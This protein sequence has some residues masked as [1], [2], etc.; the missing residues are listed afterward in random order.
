M[1][2][3]E[4]RI[5][6]TEIHELRGDASTHSLIVISNEH[7]EVHE[8][9]T[10]FIKTFL[11]DQEGSG[12][13][14]YFSF[15]TPDTTKEIHA[16]V[17]ISPDVDFEVEIFEDATVTGGTPIP[18]QNA[19]RNSTNTAD[20][21]ALAGPTVSVAGNLMWAARNGGGRDPVGVAPGLNYEIIAKRDS[22]YVFKITKRTTA[23]GVVDIDFW[24]YEHTPKTAT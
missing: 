8:G 5:S 7:H 24:W 23:D 19:N 1:P 3:L 14:T 12:N 4:A 13:I 17:A 10:Y 18:G 11:F 21:A 20:L 15:T 9:D 16:K 6:N 22:T 2:P